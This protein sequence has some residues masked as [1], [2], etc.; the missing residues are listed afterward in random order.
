VLAY[1]GFPR[2]EVV[3]QDFGSQDLTLGFGND[4]GELAGVAGLNM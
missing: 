2:K 4:Q 3:K 1:P